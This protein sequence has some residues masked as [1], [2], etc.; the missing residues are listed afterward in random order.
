LHDDEAAR[1]RAVHAL[2]DSDSAVVRAAPFF[3]HGNLDAAARPEVKIIVADAY[4]VLRRSSSEF[5]VIVSEPSHPWA[6]GVE[7]IYS[8]E[9]LEVARDHLAPGGI[10]VQ[11]M[12]LY[13]SNEETL[14]LVLRTY[15]DVFDEVSVWYGLGVDVLLLG[16][17]S[18]DR[19]VDIQTL[20]KR[21]RRPDFVAGLA[22]VG[23][24]SLPALL[25]HEI[26]PLGV[27]RALALR[28]DVHTL[29]HPRLG[30]RAA[31]AFFT[32]A[33]AHLPASGGVRSAAIGAESSIVG[34]YAAYRGGT[35][36]EVDFAELAHETCRHRATLCLTLLARW[37]HAYPNSPIRNRLLADLA[38]DPSLMRRLHLERLAAVR[39]LYEVD[40]PVL[41]GVDPLV[42]A[43]RTTDL[44]YRHY[45]HAVPFPRESLEA[46]WQTCAAEPDRRSE[47]DRERKRAEVY[48]GPLEAVSGPAISAGRAP[49]SHASGS[50]R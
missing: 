26:L 7:M 2:D 42:H 50:P 49:P 18:G 20:E 5:D 40:I 33:A 34:R 10:H 37:A 11:W 44:F 46:V 48:L 19:S 24:E 14:G 9:F 27:L 13:E 45:H 31:R 25:A 3:A 39:A 16:H 22:R 35:L 12:H 6:L 28:G 17:R 36:G 38:G 43:Q 41:A 32:G 15:L 4:R 47:C 23:I 8:R 30:D 1:A 21:V 29:L